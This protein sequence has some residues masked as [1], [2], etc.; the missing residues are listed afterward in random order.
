MELH[1]LFDQVSALQADN[2]RM[3]DEVVESE[4]MA[5]QYK[6]LVSTLLGCWMAERELRVNQQRANELVMEMRKKGESL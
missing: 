1:E 3:R 4:K 5:K 2:Q 6:H